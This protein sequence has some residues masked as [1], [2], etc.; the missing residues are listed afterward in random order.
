MG[1]AGDYEDECD[2]E[3]VANLNEYLDEGEDKE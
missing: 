2:F 3:D 1:E